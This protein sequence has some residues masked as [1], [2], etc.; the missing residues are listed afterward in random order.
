MDK[1]NK[2]HLL[3]QVRNLMGGANDN[4]VLYGNYE[5]LRFGAFYLEHF[6]AKQNFLYPNRENEVVYRTL[7]SL[8]ARKS[9]F[10]R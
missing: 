10:W 3:H 1:A 6:C 4:H 5:E 9:M 2:R 7:V 8:G